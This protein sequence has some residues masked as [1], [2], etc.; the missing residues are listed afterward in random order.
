METAHA[1]HGVQ[2]DTP[3]GRMFNPGLTTLLYSF[4]Y[5]VVVCVVGMVDDHLVSPDAHRPLC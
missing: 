1:E 3:G 4:L 5:S 2:F